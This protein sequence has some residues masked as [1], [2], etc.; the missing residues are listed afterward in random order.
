LYCGP[1][2]KKPVLHVADEKKLGAG[3]SGN[4]PMTY[5]KQIDTLN[6]THQNLRKVTATFQTICKQYFSVKL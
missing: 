4:Y 1:R 3:K 2:P 5:K 6:S